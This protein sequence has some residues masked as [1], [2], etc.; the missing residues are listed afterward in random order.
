ML[1]KKMQSTVQT[2]SSEGQELPAQQ[3]TSFLKNCDPSFLT[4][5]AQHLEKQ[6]FLPGQT[7]LEEGSDAGFSLLIQQGNASIEKGGPSL[8]VV[9]GC[10]IHSQP[11]R[12]FMGFSL[13]GRTCPTPTSY[14]KDPKQLGP[15]P[16]QSRASLRRSAFT[17]AALSGGL[18]PASFLDLHGIA[19]WGDDREGCTG[20]SRLGRAFFFADLP[21]AMH[22]DPC[23]TLAASI[24]PKDPSRHLAL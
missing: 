6:V 3:P 16:Q 14:A 19:P 22:V 23:G 11:G 24:L 1:Q 20:K 12:T 21:C 4:R 8:N 7:L 18:A 17:E 13:G 15:M 5:M 10:R 9:R 2:L